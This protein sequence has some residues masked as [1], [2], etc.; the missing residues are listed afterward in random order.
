MLASST[1]SLAGSS[2]ARSE[3]TT[4]DAL[5]IPSVRTLE[6]VGPIVVGADTT[7]T[8]RCLAEGIDVSNVADWLTPAHLHSREENTGYGADGDSKEG[9][10]HRKKA[11]RVRPLF[12]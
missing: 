3:P 2:T 11:S 10:R 7:V 9:L 1:I 5:N 8:Y 4:V 6:I 12:R